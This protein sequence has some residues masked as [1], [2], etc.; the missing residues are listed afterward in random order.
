MLTQEQTSNIIFKLLFDAKHK[1]GLQEQTKIKII[2]LLNEL[3]PEQCYMLLF[4]RPNILFFD[5][6]EKTFLIKRAL[7]DSDIVGKI[8]KRSLRS[9]P[10]YLFKI[11]F[12]EIIEK[13]PELIIDLVKTNGFLIEKN[14]NSFGLTKKEKEYL[15]SIM[16]VNKLD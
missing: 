1:T 10:M 15:D 9:L 8:A 2:D 7:I 5:K 6:N 14:I 13:N 11:M 3:S 4:N 12:R 16:I